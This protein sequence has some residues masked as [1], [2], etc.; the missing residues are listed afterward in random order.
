MVPGPDG[1]P[2]HLEMR[3]GAGTIYVSPMS[4]Q[5]SFADVSQ[6]ANI[7]VDD[8]DQH[9]ARAVA[10]GAN[11]V[12]AP[13]DTPFGARFYAVRDPEHVLWWLSTYRPSQ[14]GTA[15]PEHS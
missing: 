3:L 5:G 11:V 8:P 6:F 7:V 14:P 4:E 2:V 13:R 1:A 15:P 12:I 9:H 10:A